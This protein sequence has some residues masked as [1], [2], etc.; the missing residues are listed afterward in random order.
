MTDVELEVIDLLTHTLTLILH[1]FKNP[2]YYR[3]CTIEVVR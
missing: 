3:G 2:V 1:L